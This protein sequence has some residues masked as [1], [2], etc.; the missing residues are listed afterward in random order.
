MICKRC[1][2]DEDLRFGYCFDC[3]TEGDLRLGRRSILEHWWHAVSKARD[4]WTFKTDIKL[5]FERMF[6]RGEYA[7]GGEWEHL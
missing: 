6:R 3:A 4:W 5:G 7:P 1:G 2:K